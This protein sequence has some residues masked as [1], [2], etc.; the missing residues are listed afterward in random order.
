MTNTSAENDNTPTLQVPQ[1]QTQKL[2]ELFTVVPPFSVVSTT[3]NNKGKFILTSP[4]LQDG[5]YSVKAT[6]TDAAGNVSSKS[7]ALSVTID[8]TAPDA[9]TSLATS[10]T[11][12]SDSTPT[13]TGNA[14]VTPKL[15][16]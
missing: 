15:L 14:E 4:E 13:I 8:T 9:P 10:T 7:S 6:S 3:A 1:N 16:Y 12:T 2:Q 11:T 5:V